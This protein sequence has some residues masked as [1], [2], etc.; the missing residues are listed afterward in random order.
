MNLKP[1]KNRMVADQ[2]ASAIAGFL[3]LGAPEAGEVNPFTRAL[4][5]YLDEA[6]ALRRKALEWSWSNPFSWLR[7]R[8]INI[9]RA[10]IAA[11]VLEYERLL[12]RASADRIMAI[13]YTQNVSI[14][15]N[16]CEAREL[17]KMIRHHYRGELEEWE[18]ERRS[19][20]YMAM[21]AIEREKG[22]I[23]G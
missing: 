7:R 9:L 8:E 14:V 21:R 18:R 13:A 20:V 1:I 17:Q 12:N 22:P 19:A 23:P 16:D 3:G 2:A 5:S 11:L 4:A 10:E 15:G 6:E